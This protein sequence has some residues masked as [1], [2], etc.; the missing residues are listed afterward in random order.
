LN[1]ANKYVQVKQD[2]DL[3]RFERDEEA[4]PSANT[5]TIVLDLDETLVHS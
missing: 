5:K 1:Y 3:L 2:E 4:F